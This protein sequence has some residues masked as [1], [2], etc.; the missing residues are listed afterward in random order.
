MRIRGAVCT[1]RGWRK[2][3]H[4]IARR[5]LSTYPPEDEP[6]VRDRVLIAVYLHEEKKLTYGKRVPTLVDRDDNKRPGRDVIASPSKDVRSSVVRPSVVARARPQCACVHPVPSRVRACVRVRGREQRRRRPAHSRGGKRSQQ[7]GSAARRVRRPVVHTVYSSDLYA[8][9][10]PR[11]V[12]HVSSSDHRLF[13]RRVNSN[14]NNN[15]STKSV[16]DAH[17]TLPRIVCCSST[18]PRD[19][20]NHIII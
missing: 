14:N 8:R 11:R 6:V 9:A 4:T 3:K 5:P 10:R 13:V 17:Y 7:V 20:R 18:P 16:I 19:D 12:F 1:G 15:R 2:T